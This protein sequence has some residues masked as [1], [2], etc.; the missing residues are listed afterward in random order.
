MCI[1]SMITQEIPKQFPNWQQQFTPQQV[2]DLSEV[3][4][5]LDAIDKKLGAKDC[6]DESKAKFLEELAAL[7]QRVEELE[8]K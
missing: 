4:K 6:K 8:S 5:K 7:R 2:V 1:V 3:L